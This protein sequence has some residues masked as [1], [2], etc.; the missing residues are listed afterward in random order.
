MLD[1][2]PNRLFEF[3]PFRIDTRERM[4][5]RNGKP[6]PLTPKVYEVLLALVENRGHTLGKDELIE[7]VWTEAF[8]EAGNLNRN[9]STLRRILGDNT[10]DPEFIR[11]FP[12]HGY[13]FEAEVREIIN[14]DDALL[15]ERRTNYRLAF[16]ESA[17]SSEEST[18]L[19][20][21]SK[22]AIISATLGGILIL[23]LVLVFVGSSW[24]NSSRVA[25]TDLGSASGEN[26]RA[27]ELY[28]KARLLWQDRSGESLH[29]ATLLLEQAVAIDPGFAL[30][31]AALADAYAFDGRNWSK[32]TDTANTAITLD[33]GLGEPHA[34]IGFVKMFWEWKFFEADEYF[35]R[36]VTLSPNYATGHQWYAINLAASWRGNAALSEMRRAMELDPD[37]LAINADMCQLLYFNRRLDDAEAQCK[38]TLEMDPKFLS[39]NLHLYDIYMAKGMYDEAVGHFLSLEEMVV[40]YASFPGQLDELKKSYSTGGIRSFWQKRIE[41]LEQLPARDYEI[42]KYKARLG[43][44]D[45][46]FAHLRKSYEARNVGFMTFLAEPLFL[47]CCYLDPQFQKLEAPLMGN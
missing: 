12:K 5:S 30:G 36:A 45:Q 3:G 9:I 4:L 35:K 39:A 43:Q 1:H 16:N 34:T 10:R 8:V 40:D 15:I 28:R 21:R 22:W 6:V 14:D 11:T 17:S 24:T 7:R 13:R 38:K 27:R 2:R 42:A 46:V 37:S 25:A 18:I 44:T 32:A 41:M 29:E 19:L 23:T 26:A 47:L 31:H 20:T 33:P